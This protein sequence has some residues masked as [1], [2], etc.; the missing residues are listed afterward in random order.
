MKF[1]Y[2]THPLRSTRGT[3]VLRFVSSGV[4]KGESGFLSR[5]SAFVC[6]FPRVLRRGR[7]WEQ[8]KAKCMQE[9]AC[10]EVGT[11]SSRRH[12]FLMRC[13]M[14]RYV[15]LFRSSLSFAVMDVYCSIIEQSI[16]HCCATH[17]LLS[18]SSPITPDD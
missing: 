11:R 16:H 14:L 15:L 3:A 18:L 12:T 8:G 6:V 17:S 7:G 9:K 1:T 13:D 4:V 2:I 5:H 10:R